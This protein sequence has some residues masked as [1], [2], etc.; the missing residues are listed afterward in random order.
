M[1]LWDSVHR[2]LD[3]ASKEAARIAKIQRLRSTIDGISRQMYEQNSNLV[4]KTMELFL[5]G[6]LTQAELLPF[7]Q[8]LVNLQHQ[9][10]QAQ[11]DLKQLQANQPPAAVTQTG[12]PDE[13]LQSTGYAPPP[14]ESVSY[15]SSHEELTYV[16][17]PPEYQGYDLAVQAV[18][19]PPPPGVESATIS[20]ADTALMSTNAAQPICPVCQTALLPNH[21]FCSN[22][23]TLVRDVHA[24]HLPTFRAT[25]QESSASQE[26]ETIR[27]REP[28][29]TN[30]EGDETIRANVAPASPGNAAPSLEN[31]AQ[32]PDNKGD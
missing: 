6:Q 3:K 20:S 29:S 10:E 5:A 13:Y 28:G 9:L 4:N 8:E 32:Q 25:G 15:I 23:G 30:N 17:S 24:Q 11:N 12:I 2:G 7:C 14:P 22:C 19:P 1:P 27:A 16:P 18:A 26:Q 21:S 31:A